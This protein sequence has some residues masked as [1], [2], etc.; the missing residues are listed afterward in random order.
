[1][2]NKV[3][4][5]L[6]GLNTLFPLF[7]GWGE[8]KISGLSRGEKSKRKNERGNLAIKP[9]KIVGLKVWRAQALSDLR[10]PVV[11]LPSTDLINDGLGLR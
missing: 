10:C 8:N 2:V 7:G 5:Y 6:D 1:M 11:P 3:I 4:Y 9:V